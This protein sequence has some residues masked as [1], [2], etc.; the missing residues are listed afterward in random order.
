MK[1]LIYNNNVDFVNNTKKT[2]NFI[3][4]RTKKIFMIIGVKIVQ[5]KLK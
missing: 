2:L 1:K 4:I 3:E 5:N